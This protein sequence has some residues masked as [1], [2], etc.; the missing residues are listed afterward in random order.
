MPILSMFYGIVIRMYF[1]MVVG[2]ACRAC[3][4]STP[5]SKLYSAMT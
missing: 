3:T 4:L 1:S 2:T 5:E